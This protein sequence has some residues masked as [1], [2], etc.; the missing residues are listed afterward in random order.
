MGIGLIELE[1]RELG[2][3][4]SGDALVPKIAVDLVDALQSSH[5]EAFQVELRG[6]AQIE[7]QIESVVVGDERPREST[8]G[9]RLHHRRLDLDIAAL[10][11]ESPNRPDH[12]RTGLED[13]AR[14]W[15]DGQVEVTLP[16]PLLDVLQAVP[17]FR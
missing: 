2:V 17:F 14:L 5:D 11:E 1:H 6:Y 15:I 3:V 8:A 9:D 12:C 4:L 10:V 13:T 7:L 16:V